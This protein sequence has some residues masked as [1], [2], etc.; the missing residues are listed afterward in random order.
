MM[1][2]LGTWLFHPMLALGGLAVASPILIH[3]LSRRRVRRVRWPAMEFLLEAQRRRRRRV[4]IEQLLL[5]LLRCLVVLVLTLLV[6]RP[7]IRP[8]A[9]AAILGSAPRTD[10]IIL[11][12]DSY[13]MAYRAGP[14]ESV[15]ERAT[16][17]VGQIVGWVSAEFPGD[18]LTLLR[19]SAP[20]E[21]AVAVSRLDGDG[22][23]RTT[24]R[25]S[26][27]TVSD[28]RARFKE[29]IAAVA[30]HIEES[31]GQANTVVYVVGDFQR[32]DWVS[33]DAR[34]P[35]ASLMEP[36][37][38]R[39][40]SQLGLSVV[41]V[42]VGV[43]RAANV[44]VTAIEERVPQVVAGVRATYD[45]TVAN[46]GD[47]AVTDAELQVSVA[48][49]AWP[50]QPLAR[51]EPFSTVRQA[52]EVTFG[53]EGGDRLRVEVTGARSA[54][55]LALDDRRTLGVSVLSAVPILIV[56]GEPNNDAYRD[57]VFLLRTALNPPGEILSGNS[58]RVIDDEQ[59]V[60]TELQAFA[61]VVLANVY[62]VSDAGQEKLARYVRDGG[63]LLCFLGDQVDPGHY[64]DALYAGGRGFLPAEL[65]DVLIAPSASEGVAFGSFD[66]THPVFRPFAGAAAQLLRGVRVYQYVTVT[67]A[68]AIAAES[69]PAAT[70]PG[71]GMREE[72]ASHGIPAARVLASL[73]DADRSPLLLER[74]YGAGRVI[75]CTTTADLEWNG[76]ARDP[77][78]VAMMLQLSQY[79]ARRSSESG[80]TLVGSPI[81]VELDPTVFSSNASLRLPSYPQDPALSLE[82]RA[83]GVSLV[84]TWDRTRRA[85]A[86]TFV[87]KTLAGDET[88]RFAACNPDAAESD[89]RRATPAELRTACEGV[90]ATYVRDVATLS[91]ESREA[92]RELWWP[93]LLVAIGLLVSEQALARWFG[94]RG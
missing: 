87:L 81:R 92:R 70:Q 12:D 85:G 44:A 80:Q 63:G 75:L 27:L 45:V 65:G 16:R 38:R 17:A 31:A 52:V 36:L 6:A 4:Q 56:D 39:S 11:L 79:L 60:A 7:F 72:S 33:S 25:L 5:L 78:Y 73:E 88:L 94:S 55:R 1:S 51:I 9:A 82:A 35:E 54:N 22:V 26:L 64:N 62:R 37:R 53:R 41:L 91:G 57:E 50:A 23:R 3:I 59:L 74:S 18:S 29:A 69:R 86:Y 49:Q 48:E 13:S 42:D 14:N 19:L 84:L 93:L 24:D 58:V 21:A 40:E 66:E 83:Q 34:S 47:E 8:S 61:L 67:P 68:G 90:A 20:K 77:S 15:F 89:L 10:R 43:D 30:S 76:W 71:A 32:V 46:F 28:E 2:W